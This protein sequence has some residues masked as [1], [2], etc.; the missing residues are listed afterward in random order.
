M[1][2]KIKE[3]TPHEE[4]PGHSYRRLFTNFVI[5]LLL[6]SH[7]ELKTLFSGRLVS[8]DSRFQIYHGILSSGIP[9]VTSFSSAYMNSAYSLP[10]PPPTPPSSPPPPMKGIHRAILISRRFMNFFVCYLKPSFCLKLLSETI[11]L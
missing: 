2:I 10:P 8:S 6:N 3:Y 9:L 11:Q 4:Y 1:W 7:K 5:T